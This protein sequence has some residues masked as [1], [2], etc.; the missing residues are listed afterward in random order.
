MVMIDR[1]LDCDETTTTTAF[2][3]GDECIFADN[4]VLT[5]EGMIENIAQTCA[6]RIGY[7]N[8]LAGHA[9]K[10]GFIGA[11]KGFEYTERPRLGE[12]VETT[13]TVREE[14]FGITLVDASM[15]LGSKEIARTT[16]KIALSD[17]DA[18]E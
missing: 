14:V 16:M 2:T 13:V 7:L 17:I 15:K 3:V 8:H 1:L 9:V 4:G 11:I 18:K 12:T 5:A 10:L 6:A